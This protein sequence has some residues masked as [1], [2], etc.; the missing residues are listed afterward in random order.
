MIGIPF[1]PPERFRTLLASVDGFVLPSKGG[2]PAPLQEA[3]LAG[4]PCVVAPHPGYDRYLRPGDVLE[5]DPSPSAI[6]AALVALRDDPALREGSLAERARAAGDRSFGVDAFASAYLQL[7]RELLD[8]R[9]GVPSDRGNGMGAEDV[10]ADIAAPAGT[11]AGTASSPSTISGTAVVSSSRQGR[12][13]RRPRAA[14]RS[15]SRHTTA[16]R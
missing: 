2:I 1:L 13:R 11:L 8:A 4:L 5:V 12:R 9:Q 10:L 6:R 7:Y 14:S 15:V 16:R 3:L